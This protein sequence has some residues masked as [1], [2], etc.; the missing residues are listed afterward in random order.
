MK[1]NYAIALGLCFFIYS[2][3]DQKTAEPKT[4]NPMDLVVNP[5]TADAN[6]DLSQLGTLL[7]ED[8]T[9]DFKEINEGDVVTHTFKYKNVGK[10]PVLITEANTSCGCTVPDYK[11]EPIAPG[12]EGEINV[13]FNSEGKHGDIAK[14]V[15]VKSNGNPAIQGLMIYAKIRN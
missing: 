13:K 6:A 2:C 11:K 15:Y 4:N 12:E 7:F 3:G 9:F 1:R 14:S 5:R 8:T 10:S